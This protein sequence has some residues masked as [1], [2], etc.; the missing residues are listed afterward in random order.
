VAQRN[1]IGLP[2]PPDDFDEDSMTRGPMILC[3]T[4]M[5]T[6]GRKEFTMK[7]ALG[8]GRQALLRSRSRIPN[9]RSSPSP[10]SAFRT[11][12]S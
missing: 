12:C 2:S 7:W 1:R 3:I 5:K 8:G 9:F 4:K 6:I 10:F 11:G